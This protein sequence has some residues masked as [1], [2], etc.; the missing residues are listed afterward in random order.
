M[1]PVVLAAL[2]LA[3]LVIGISKTSVG[4]FAVIAV[5]VFASVMPAKEST[6]AVL[7]LLITG[8]LVAVQRYR[9][10]ADW[11]LLRRL[12][13]AV[14]PGVVLG[15]AFLWVVSD[16]VLRRTIGAIILAL[17]VLQLV[18]RRR[19]ARL[20]ASGSAAADAPQADHPIAGP[21]VGLAAGF[22]TMTANAAGAVV[23]LYLLAMRVEKLRFIGTGAWFFLIVNLAKVP[24]SAG[25]GL[26]PASTLWLTAGLA[27]VVLLGAWLGTHVTGRL[28]QQ[29]FERAALAGSAVAAASLLLR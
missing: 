10:A 28:S 29:G 7:L 3:A 27:P 8:D 11:G 15:A 13:P 25:L 19:D 9:H 1:S 23:A 18:L 2:A 12:L 17:L 14:L 22:T 16:V 20:R 26:F 24:F 5:A 4:G 6:A 21:A